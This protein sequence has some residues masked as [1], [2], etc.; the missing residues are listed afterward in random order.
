[1]DDNL[2]E[3]SSRSKRQPK[4]QECLAKTRHGDAPELLMLML[5][6]YRENTPPP[7]PC[8]VAFFLQIYL[9]MKRISAS[10]MIRKGGV[11]GRVL[12]AGRTIKTTPTTKARTRR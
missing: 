7:N 6:S 1:M 9:Y 8:S 11:L 10:S 5:L 4:R 2:F 3:G 12:T